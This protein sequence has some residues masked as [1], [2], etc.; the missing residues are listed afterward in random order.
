MPIPPAAP[1]TN[2]VGVTHGRADLET[3][4]V[5]QFHD[6]PLGCHHALGH[7]T[8][9][10]AAGHAIAHAHALDAIANSQHHPRSVAARYERQGGLHLVATGHHQRIHEAQC[11]HMD[12]NQHLAWTWKRVRKLAKLKCVNAVEA[13]ADDGAHLSPAPSR[14]P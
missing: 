5:G 11:G 7:A 1:L 14:V 8:M 2:T 12:V 9:P 3:Y 4:A 13:P 10:V 6:P